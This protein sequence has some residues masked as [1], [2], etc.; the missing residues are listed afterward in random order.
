MD[1]SNSPIGRPVVSC[2]RLS[3]V[4]AR[5]ERT[6]ARL[7]NALNRLTFCSQRK[8]Y[9]I[10]CS[11]RERNDD[12]ACV[13]LLAPMPIPRVNTLVLLSAFLPT[14]LSVCRSVCG[15]VRPSFCQYV[16]L[17]GL[18]FMSVCLPGWLAGLH[19][20]TTALAKQVKHT[21]YNRFSKKNYL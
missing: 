8:F 2:S 6:R 18:S 13:Y 20:S 10:A 12:C 15:S 9:K 3:V 4:G 17:S 16:C 5:E 11:E 21:T 7:P 14:C 1:A 19:C